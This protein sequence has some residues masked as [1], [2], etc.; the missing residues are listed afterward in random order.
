MTPFNPSS[1]YDVVN[2]DPF[3]GDARDLQ[4]SQLVSG[5]FAQFTKTGNPNPDLGFLRARG[6]T[7]AS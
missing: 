3:S 5:Y 4:A 1:V 7:E 6:Y 2:A